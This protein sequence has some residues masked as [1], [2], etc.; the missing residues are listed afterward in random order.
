VKKKKENKKENKKM[1]CSGG[2]PASAFVSARAG[3]VYNWCMRLMITQHIDL[4]I[5]YATAWTC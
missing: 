4:I 5:A 1:K 3:I 2:G